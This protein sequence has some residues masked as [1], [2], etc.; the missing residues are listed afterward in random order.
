MCVSLSP[1]KVE[2]KRKDVTPSPSSAKMMIYLIVEEG[3]ATW[4]EFPLT[5]LSEKQ[6]STYELNEKESIVYEC[7]MHRSRAWAVLATPT[8]AQSA[9]ICQPFHHSLPRL[10]LK[11]NPK[12]R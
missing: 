8:K 3:Y 9:K 6:L 1:V 2:K 4:L 5:K 11:S 12:K 7:E 10:C